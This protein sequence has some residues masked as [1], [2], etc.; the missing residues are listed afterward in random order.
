MIAHQIMSL[1]P[2]AHDRLVL[3]SGDHIALTGFLFSD[4]LEGSTVVGEQELADA[5]VWFACAAHALEQ[6][7]QHIGRVVVRGTL[8]GIEA[9]GLHT[10]A[11]CTV[12]QQGC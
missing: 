6:R 9:H 1:M 11:G 5:F 8:N 12:A 7:L 2:R 10:H 4:H 3:K